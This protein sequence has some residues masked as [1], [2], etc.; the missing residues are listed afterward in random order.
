MRWAADPLFCQA[1]SWTVGLSPRVI[2]RHWAALIAGT[3]ADFRRWGVTLDARLVGYVDLANLSTLSG[4]LGV[5]IGERSLW[6]Q[7]VARRA[8]ELLLQEAWELGLH[9]V[10]A[11]VHRPNM[12]SHALMRRLGFQQ[13][14]IRRPEPYYGV[15]VAVVQY[16]LKRQDRALSPSSADTRTAG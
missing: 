8:C 6:G 11:E 10:T 3:Q 2:R 7:G 1:A 13:C 5:A 12:R 4:E 15:P 16:V 9:T 14:G